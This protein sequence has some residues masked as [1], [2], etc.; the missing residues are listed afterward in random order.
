MDIQIRL[1]TAFYNKNEALLDLSQ[2]PLFLNDDGMMTT[3]A[4]CLLSQH[5]VILRRL[6]ILF[7]SSLPP[8]RCYPRLAHNVKEARYQTHPCSVSMP[9]LAWKSQRRRCHRNTLELLYW[10]FFRKMDYRPEIPERSMSQT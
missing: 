4:S 6:H 1:S 2:E 3:Y 5:L 9:C 7:A 8:R 10:L